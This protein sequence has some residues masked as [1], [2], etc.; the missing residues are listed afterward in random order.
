M[1]AQ[2]VADPAPEDKKA[3][4]G[5]APESEEESEEEEEEEEGGA[6]SGGGSGGG[7]AARKPIT[8]A[9]PQSF[10]R[11]DPARPAKEL[12]K[13]FPLFS[14]ATEA[15]CLLAEGEML[16]LPAG[17]FH[18]V[19]SLAGDKGHAAFNYW[20]QPPDA[21]SFAKPYS[22]SMWEEDIAARPI[23]A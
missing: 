13:K 11:V 22:R 16:F 1:A 6:S 5:K 21:A 9:D 3:K 19:C 17:W 15:T 20:F 7:K 8:T 18:E 14:G 10:S 4:R 2:P 12:K 23:G